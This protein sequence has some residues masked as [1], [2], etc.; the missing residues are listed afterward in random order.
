MATK[1]PECLYDASEIDT[2]TRFDPTKKLP[3]ELE[4]AWIETYS[5]KKFH[6]LSPD[7]AEV[8]IVD[9]AHALSN[10]C[11]F[12]GHVSRF[13]SVAE[14][15]VAVSVCC[16]HPLEGLLHDASEA[17]IGD[18]VSPLKHSLHRYKRIEARI[19]ACISARFE[20]KTPFP[21]DVKDAD[22][23]QLK[24]EAYWLL[25]SQGK[26]WTGGW[27][28]TRTSGLMPQCWTPEEAEKQFLMRF[29]HLTAK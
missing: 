2:E 6:I 14:H 9:I 24:E 16:Q 21:H 7:P 15:S 8:D 4:N 11:R 27:F 5:G 18:L 3:D 10:S 25:P 12:G 1:F 13:Y 20:L 28:S 17:Y 19:M 22:I 23:A 26:T 29:Y